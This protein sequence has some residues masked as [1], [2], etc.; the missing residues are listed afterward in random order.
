[1]PRTVRLDLPDRSVSYT[2]DRGVFAAAQVDPA[3]K[4]LLLDAPP[5][6]DTG[7]FLDLGCGY[8]PIACTLA[9][10]RPRASIWAVD[11]NRRAL[12]LCAANAVAQGLANVSVFEPTTTPNRPLDLIWSNPPIRI[13][14]HALH[15][16]LRL[17]LGRLRTGGAGLFVVHRHLGSDSLQRWLDTEGW[18]TTRLG[19]RDGNRLL[20]VMAP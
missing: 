11:V 19:S 8:G 16:L 17:W 4:Y 15:D 7:T 5:P 18:P 10:R 20:R 6:P 13:G 9:A 1:A 2:T 14:K 12:D 3:T